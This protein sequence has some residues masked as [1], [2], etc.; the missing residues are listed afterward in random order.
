MTQNKTLL[1]ITDL[2]PTH[3][4]GLGFDLRITTQQ[5]CHTISVLTGIHSDKPILHY[6]LDTYQVLQQL[7]LLKDCNIC[8]I[9]LGL[10]NFQEIGLL[11]G[12]KLQ[13]MFADVPIVIDGRALIPNGKKFLDSQKVR[14]FCQSILKMT[15]ILVIDQDNLPSLAT[16]LCPNIIETSK[17][18][19]KIIQYGCKYLLLISNSDNKA[20][21]N[22]FHDG[23]CIQMSQ[24]STTR[25]CEQEIAT[26]LSCCIA[27]GI[28]PMQSLQRLSIY[29]D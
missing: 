5:K 16:H 9:R 23:Q 13:K 20:T 11:I 29:P 18:L 1:I 6:C 19:E 26:T 10:L 2:N 3:E 28:D 22:L 21:Y 14:K 15:L 7:E 17:Q 25:M 8:A 12:Q 24:N 4:T 27:Q